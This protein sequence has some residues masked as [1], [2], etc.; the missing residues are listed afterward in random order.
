MLVPDLLSSS[1]TPHPNMVFRVLYVAFFE[2]I[3]E[4]YSV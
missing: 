4:A 1:P 2:Q 3:Q